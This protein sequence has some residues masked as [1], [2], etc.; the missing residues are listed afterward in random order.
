MDPGVL[1]FTRELDQPDSRGIPSA[2]A[3]PPDSVAGREDLPLTVGTFRGH[4]SACFSGSSNGRLEHYGMA[5]SGRDEDSFAL[6]AQGDDRAEEMAV[7][8]AA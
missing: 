1:S 4:C 7:A 3:P 6:R 2:P 5:G 8:E